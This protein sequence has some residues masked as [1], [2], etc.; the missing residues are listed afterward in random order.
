MIVKKIEVS[1]SRLSTL[2]PNYRYKIASWWLP[3]LKTMIGTGAGYESY[4]CNPPGRTETEEYVEHRDLILNGL[5][6]KVLFDCNRGLRGEL[7]NED[8][9]DYRKARVHPIKNGTVGAEYYNGVCRAVTR[10]AP[11]ISE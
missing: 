7:L 10:K 6:T 3:Y 5:K 11:Y 9:N 8:E 1:V 4:R 2:H